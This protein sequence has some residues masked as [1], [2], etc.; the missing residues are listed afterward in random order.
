MK[1][2]RESRNFTAPI[3]EKDNGCVAP[4]LFV[5]YKDF[6]TR[7][8]RNRANIMKAATGRAD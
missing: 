3:L 1:E 4:F 7:K 5:L 6:L 2:G 8:I